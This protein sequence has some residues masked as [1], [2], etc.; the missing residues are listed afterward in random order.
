MKGA[1]ERLT[2]ELVITQ[3][4]EVQVIQEGSDIIE[5]EHPDF[6][7]KQ[8]IMKP[9]MEILKEEVIEVNEERIERVAIAKQWTQE[10][11]SLVESQEDVD[12]NREGGDVGKTCNDH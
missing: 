9:L 10:V 3:T 8:E 12:K 6:E 5:K 2:D 7:L 4:Y 11:N 1:E